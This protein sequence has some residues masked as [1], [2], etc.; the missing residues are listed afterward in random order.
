MRAEPGRRW[1]I[2][3]V[4]ILDPFRGVDTV[5]DVAVADGRFAEPAGEAAERWDG[6][7]LWLVPR[8]TDMH[9][10][11]R[12]PGQEWKEDL[13]SGLE[14]A[15]AGGFT[16]VA[17]MPNTTPVVDEPAL[18]RWQI[19]R[20]RTAGLARLWPLG[21][22]TRGSEGRELAPM[23]RLAEAGA[24]GFSDDG[25]PVS[26]A[27]I[28]RAALSY[29]AGLGRPV[30]Q[31]ALD[32]ALG[33]DGVMNEGPVSA[34]LGLP[35]QPEL[36]EAVVV[37]RDVL[38]AGLTGGPLHVAHVSSPASLDAVAY[39]RRR[40]WRVSAEATPHH[41]YF[42][43]EAVAEW[44]YDPV[45]KV[46]PPLRGEATRQ[47]LL[48]AVEEGLVECFASDHA[49]HHADEKALPYDQAPFGISGLE[50]ALAATLT[51]L[52]PRGRMS[53]LEF[54][55][56]WTT[57]PHRV[58]GVS[59]GGVVPGEAADFTLI[60]PQAVWEV[61]PARFRSKGRNTPFAG[62]RLT[63]RAVAVVVG[64]RPVMREGEVLRQDADA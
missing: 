60:D 57:G 19:D 16:A 33:G 20:A 5:G 17:T 37:W 36:A 7:G 40:G 38:L 4:R 29:A 51:A 56:R 64:G 2:N 30:I 62:V 52:L 13:D 50:T 58:L 47:A 24:A 63:G 28:M 6:R 10:H 44:A 55:A 39:G 26:S 25:R 54:F 59:Y 48:E 53:P 12:A 31:H 32:L 45:T 34:R 41:L 43:D 21:A 11:F 42:T 46:N 61:D 1:V 9:V 18:V 3:G 23:A 15:V 22:I 49:P 14:A 35:G 8:L 27:L